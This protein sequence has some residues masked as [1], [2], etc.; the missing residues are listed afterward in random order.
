MGGQHFNG[1]FVEHSIFGPERFFSAEV[2]DA[3]AA[4]FF[5][6]DKDAVDRSLKW[7]VH[8][9]TDIQEAGDVWLIDHAWEFDSC[10]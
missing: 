9:A 4:F 1:T 5:Q 3:G 2:F 10:R 8:S 6:V 7:S